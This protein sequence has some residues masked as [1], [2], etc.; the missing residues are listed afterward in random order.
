[1]AKITVSSTQVNTFIQTLLG[2]T[3]RPHFVRDLILPKVSV[4]KRG[5]IIPTWGNAH[6]RI[7]DLKRGLQDRS[8][9]F[10]ES[11]ISANKTYNI[12]DYDVAGYVP[13]ALLEN[14]DRPFELAALESIT[15]QEILELQAEDALATA[16]TNSAVL[17]QYTTLSGTSQW[18]DYEESTPFEDIEDAKTTVFNA[19]GMEPNTIVIPREVLVSLKQHPDYNFNLTRDAKGLSD[20]D[21][22]QI[23]K[24]KHGFAEVI[25]PK[26]R[27]ITTI[28][29]Q[30]ES[31]GSVWGKHVVLFYKAQFPSMVS[32]SF[33]YSFELSGFDVSTKTRREPNADKGILVESSKAFDDKI[34]M[35]SAAY[36]LKAAVS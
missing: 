23:L 17:T 9:H 29:G 24:D 27:K 7:Y 1:M 22:V 31:F 18:S 5:G 11:E 8:L 10:V 36:L 2:Q 6:M 26:A 16:M 3:N 19:C 13:D 33:G 15:K 34:L 30:T 20:G 14:A 35:P 12:E 28:D 25:V 21:I 4:N 32:P